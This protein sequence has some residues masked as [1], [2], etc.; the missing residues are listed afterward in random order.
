MVPFCVHQLY[1]L[2]VHKIYHSVS[3]RGDIVLPVYHD[4]LGNPRCSSIGTTPEV[5]TICTTHPGTHTAFLC[6]H[7]N[8]DDF[9]GATIL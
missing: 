4:I 3:G 1:G 8:T 6:P 7:S 9:Q 2:V 5:C